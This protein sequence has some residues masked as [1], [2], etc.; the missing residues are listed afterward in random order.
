[1]RVD[2]GEAT[3]LEGDLLGD[4]YVRHAP[5]A[6]R[7]AFLLTGDGPLAE[8]LV[9]DAFVR[10]AGRLVHLRSEPMFHAYLRATVVNLV[11]SHARRVAVERRHAERAEREP[12]MD[13]PDISERD[14]MR[15]AL[16]R[17]PVRQRTAV[18]LRYYEDLPEAEVAR[19]MRLR[20][21]AVRSLVARGMASLRVVVDV[22]E[23]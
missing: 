1:M 15:S 14:R 2:V 3:R 19:L 22:E 11:R 17:L 10:L 7:L 4:L 16:M 20:G 23:S 18:V 9:Q 8:D 12:P 5:D 13:A 21:S 6:V